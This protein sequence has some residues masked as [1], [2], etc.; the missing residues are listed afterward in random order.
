MLNVVDLTNGNTGTLDSWTMRFNEGWD[1]EMFIGN[2]LTVQGTARVRDELLVEYGAA[3]VFT[4]TS[5]SETARFSGE[6][7]SSIVYL[8][9]AGCGGGLTLSTTCKTDAACTM[10][11]SGRTDFYNCDGTRGNCYTSGNSSPQTCTT[12]LIGSILTY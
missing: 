12:T 3:L 10:T 11:Y 1:G 5:G 8:E 6:S 2:E 7:A 9:P 4:D